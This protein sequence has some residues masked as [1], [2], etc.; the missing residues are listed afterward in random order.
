[1]ADDR[2]N[3]GYRQAA[4]LLRGAVRALKR[5]DAEAA[6]SLAQQACAMAPGDNR[7]PF[8]HGLALLT[9]GR[10]EAAVAPLE[11]A[12]KD[13]PDPAVETN[14]GTA[15]AQCGRDGEALA[16][17]R[18][19]VSREPPF[20][21][22]FFRLGVLLHLQ[23]HLVEAKA[24]LQR[25]VALAPDDGEPQLVLADVL[26]EL[27]E[28]AATKDAYTRA[29]ALR[30]GWPQARRGIARTLM[31][32]GDFAGAVA[33]LR[34]LTEEDGGDTRSLLDLAFC[35]QEL[36]AFDE[37]LATYRQACTTNPRAY[38]QVLHSLLGASR[39]TFWLR[40]SELAK[41]LPRPR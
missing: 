6:E 34:R 23:H 31:D 36:G 32:T 9:L 26:S 15:L 11:A 33:I 5:G 13:N 38:K 2:A 19:A 10:P 21:Q 24:V 20:P 1:M 14:L 3:D 16:C 25:A 17:F 29:L 40:P 4:E 22:A 8:I 18:R 41:R 12:A 30:P 27:G 7:A 28:T 37:A 35:L 39:G